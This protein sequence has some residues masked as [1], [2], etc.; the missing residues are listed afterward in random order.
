MAEAARAAG[1]RTIVGYNYIHN[2]AI[3]NACRLVADGTIG[4]PIHFRGTVD[5]D[6]QADPDLPWTWRARR[7]D[8][9]LGPWATWGATWRR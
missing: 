1:V 3:S 2:P 9:G 6:Y 8:A 5:E 4:R 7:A